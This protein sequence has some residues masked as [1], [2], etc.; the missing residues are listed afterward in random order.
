MPDIIVIGSGVIGLSAAL[1]LQRAGYETHILTRELPQATTSVAAGAMWSASALEG[2]LRRWADVTLNR[3]LPMTE[4]ADSGVAMQRMREVFAAPMPEPW[5]QE[6]LPYCRRLSAD[7]LPAGMADGYLMDVPVVAPPIYL[8]HLQERFLADGG[9]IEER[10]V[11]S[12]DALADEAPLLVNCSGVGARELAGDAGVYPIRGQTILI[13]APHIS[14]G[15]MDNSEITHIFPRADGV[16]LGGI[17]REG[18][19]ERRV[20]PE[21]TRDIMAAC[22]RI[23]PSV[24]SA[25]ILRYFAG[26]RPGRETVRLEMERLPSGAA[27]I[28]NY[29]HAAIG[30]TLSWGCAADTLQLAQNALR[31]GVEAT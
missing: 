16:L 14:E 7:E 1:E 24:E 26:L 25:P 21:I 23:E 11:E 13:D 18:D 4:I 5:Y 10:D 2:R 12:L 31:E 15:Y 27:V 8:R 3:F 20:D 22:A 17:K 19:G 28:H 29:G 9:C 30:Y 6:R